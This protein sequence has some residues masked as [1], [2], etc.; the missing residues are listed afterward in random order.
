M[1]WPI[2]IGF[3]A[4]LVLSVGAPVSPHNFIGFFAMWGA[5]VFVG[6]IVQGSD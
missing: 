4:A 1:K 3:I 6:W 5:F 2:I